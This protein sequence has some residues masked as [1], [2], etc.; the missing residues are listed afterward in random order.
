MTFADNVG[1]GICGGVVDE[2]GLYLT[3]N[4]TQ[5]GIITQTELQLFQ[6]KSFQFTAYKAKVLYQMH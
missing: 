3:A 1:S 5:C 2:T 4:Y 6:R